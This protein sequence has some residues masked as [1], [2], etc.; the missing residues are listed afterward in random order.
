VAR[1]RRPSRSVL[2]RRW[3]AVG[4]ILL[5]GLLYYRPLRS[6]IETRHALDARRAQ[7]HALEVEKATLVR[8]L[9]LSTSAAELAREARRLG[10]VHPG[11]KLFIVKGIAQWR[12]R[13]T[14]HG[15]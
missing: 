6:W 8:R 9:T 5:V 13:L 1:R 10:Y 2:L 14:G 15:R 12:A 7:V 3:L 4:A 11:E